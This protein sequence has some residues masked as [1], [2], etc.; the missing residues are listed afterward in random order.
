[1]IFNSLKCLTIIVLTGTVFSWMR[2][3][4]LFSM[5][6][7]IEISGWTPS[8]PL[9]EELAVRTSVE[10]NGFLY[11]VGGRQ[12]DNQP[13]KEV[14]F[15]S[16][17]GD[18]LLSGW[19]ITSELPGKGL[20]LHSLSAT[21]KHIYVIGGWDRTTQYNRVLRAT[22]LPNGQLSAWTEITPSYPDALYFHTTVI[23]NNHIYGI[24]G[25]NSSIGSNRVYH[26]SINPDTG[27]L[28]SWFRA[29]DL[30]V[31]ILYR[32][33]SV[34]YNDFIYVIGGYDGV[35]VRNEIYHATVNPDGTLGVWQTVAL[36]PNPR[37]YHQTVI[38]DGRLVV[39][40]GRMFEGN[41]L[42][43]VIAASI[44]DDG[45]L[46]EWYFMP[47]LPQTLHRFAAV[48]IQRHN[49]DYIYV[50]GG[51]NGGMKQ[52]AVYHSDVPPPPT[53]T[54]N[55]TPTATP[56]PTMTPTPTTTPTPTPALGLNNIPKGNIP[57]GKAIVY[58]ITY[59]SSDMDQLQELVLT[60]PIP[61]GVALIAE[62]IS[63]DQIRSGLVSYQ[64]ARPPIFVIS[65]Q[66]PFF[67]VN[68]FVDLTMSLDGINTTGF[69]FYVNAKP[70]EL[71]NG[72]NLDY[73]FDKPGR[74]TFAI[75]AS[76]DNPLFEELC[77]EIFVTAVKARINVNDLA[78]ET[79]MINQGD[80]VELSAQILPNYL[81]ADEFNYSWDIGG[82][83]LRGA[84][85][86]SIA[87][88][89]Y[90]ELGEQIIDLKITHDELARPIFVTQTLTIVSDDAVNSGPTIIDRVSQTNAEPLCEPG[91]A[92]FEGVIINEGV[93]AQWRFQDRT[94]VTQSNFTINN[95]FDIYLP[96]VGR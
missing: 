93:R 17:N 90:G 26:A 78:H 84:S 32:H 83:V 50:M 71:K 22:F 58:T 87:T 3:N 15:A 33:M 72:S 48:S 16:L 38:H 35:N 30:P 18:G 75:I 66:K 10:K 61:L 67:E 2:S 45:S 70:I 28:G 55:P 24:G 77:S 21:D 69:K 95:G 64:V 94:M 76:H 73:T 51:I 89:T 62:R 14:Y 53:A 82:G 8:T 74:Y 13:S 9:F 40:G 27:D 19:Q 41:D 44:N 34:A 49:S 12:Q 23:V 59:D 4:V 25:R 65:A 79:Y 91:P 7:A 56:T 46:G 54:P 1:M 88:A 6:P 47:S 36:L 5:T 57:Y 60:N 29:V 85:T 96:Y 43:S 52:N 63:G 68:R 31:P 80:T 37:E 20:Y 86:S 42:S 39:I 92:A 81:K 11:I